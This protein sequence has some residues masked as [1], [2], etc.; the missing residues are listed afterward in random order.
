MTSKISIF[1]G[2]I[3]RH[4]LLADAQICGQKASKLC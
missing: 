2:R 3:V 4:G 1:M